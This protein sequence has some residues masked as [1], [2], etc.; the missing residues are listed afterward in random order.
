M[1]KGDSPLCLLSMGVT[2]CIVA[3]GAHAGDVEFMC[4]ATLLKHAKMGWE[5]HIIHMTLGERGHPKLSPN[6][7]GAQKQAE[8]RNAA[9]ILR[10]SLH[11]M[12]FKDGELSTSEG[13][14]VELAKLLRKLRPKVVITHWRES[15]HEDHVATHR[16]VKR[17][18][19]MA[20]NPHFELAGLTPSPYPR[21]Y[22]AENWEDEEGF[23]PFVYVD[24]TDVL[25]EWERA[26]KAYAIG[27]GE[28]AFPYWD[29]YFAK[30]R[31]RG[32]ECGTMY[33][34]AFAV[35]A[36]RMRQVVHSL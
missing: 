1:P 15:I 34:Q 20:V 26:F 4:G 8:A 22:Y 23:F 36:N 18:I 3:V 13:A 9:S 29:W 30:A 16:I 17:A 10:S 7:Y 27:R 14:P 21:L 33:A 31:I 12:P 24:I 35:D 32:I 25:E 28:G 6:E 19:F 11:I 5:A 2:D